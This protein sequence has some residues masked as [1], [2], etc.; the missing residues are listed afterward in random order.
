MG[1]ATEATLF[2]TDS[3]ATKTTR[4]YFKLIGSHYLH[5]TLFN[6]VTEVVNNPEG[7]EVCFNYMQL[8]ISA[9]LIQL[10]VDPTKAG[11]TT[12]IA[13]N[14]I[15][16]RAAAQRFLDQVVNSMKSVPMYASI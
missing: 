9:I 2:R 3:I 15:V 13:A 4:A 6:L 11:P 16:L 10:K 12:D 1:I 8:I 14:S 7:Y 5:A